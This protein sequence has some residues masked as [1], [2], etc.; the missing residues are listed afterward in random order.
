M[1]RPPNSPVQLQLRLSGWKA[2]AVGLVILAT[3]IAAL[4]L[5]AI[6]FFVFFLPVLI[7]VPVLYYFV[8]KLRP[9]RFTQ[10]DA[11]RQPKDGGAVIDGDFRVVDARAVEVNPPAAG[12]GRP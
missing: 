5:L 1:P 9:R 6:G 8:P 7:L 10:T 4:G 11:A 3:I 2:I 12:V